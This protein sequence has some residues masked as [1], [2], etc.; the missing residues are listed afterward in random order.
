MAKDNKLDTSHLTDLQKHVTMEGGTE[1]AFHNEYWDN[2]DEGIYVDVITGDPLFSSTDKFDSGTGWP[3]FTKPIDDN[4]LNETSDTTHGMTRTEIKSSSSNSH[5]GHVFDDGPADKGGKRFC[6]NSAALEFIPKS[7]LAKR[8]YGKYLKLFGEKSTKYEKAYL[9]GGCFWGMEKLFS[10]LRGVKDVVNGYSGGT[11]K[12]PSYEIITTGITGH[13]E[14]I[15]VTFDPEE[16]SYEKILK[17]FFQIHDPTTLNRQGNDIGSQYRS[18]IFY[19]NNLQKNAAKKII[20]Q[21]NESGVFKS[22]VV[23]TTEK[24]DEFFRAE[25]YHQDYLKKHPYGYSCHS[26]RSEWKF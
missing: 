16:I 11:F 19:I 8:G 14:T 10:G 7:D 24:F 15:E 12:D 25:E 9:A 18:A 13:A 22:E 17:F 3:S 20:R 2:H 1:R 21:A 5:L 4:V 23:T 26:V 6:M